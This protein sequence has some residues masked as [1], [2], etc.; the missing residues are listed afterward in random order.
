MKKKRL[1]NSFHG[2]ISWQ[3]SESLNGVTK[4]N[5]SI[6]YK[7]LVLFMSNNTCLSYHVLAKSYSCSEHI[8]GRALT[9]LGFKPRTLFKNQKK[10]KKLSCLNITKAFDLKTQN[11]VFLHTSWFEFCRT[12]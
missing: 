7:A 9:P 5:L 11:N 8:I 6:Q 3:E 2:H 12:L 10:K 1:F 4:S